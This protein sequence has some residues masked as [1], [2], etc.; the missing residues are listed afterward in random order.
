MCLSIIKMQNG[1]SCLYQQKC[2]KDS[3]YVCVCVCV[4]TQKWEQ[5][6]DSPIPD[7]RDVWTA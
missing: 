1:P 2:V 6:V 3:C 5:A 7:P 4:S